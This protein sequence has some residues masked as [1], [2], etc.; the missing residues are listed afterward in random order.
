MDS[1]S[2][3]Y[4][5]KEGTQTQRE[6]KVVSE[7]RFLACL[8]A[9]ACNVNGTRVH[10]WE[11]CICLFRSITRH[12]FWGFTGT[13]EAET[14]PSRKRPERKNGV[15]GCRHTNLDIRDLTFRRD[16]ITNYWADRVRHRTQEERCT[17]TK[18]NLSPGRIEAS[19]SSGC[20]AT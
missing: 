3:I 15:Q 13:T 20:S 9:T 5:Y 1:V 10:T 16:Q 6:H 17:L 18:G 12:C 11:P 2:R 7:S 14:N 4:I 19:S 8:V